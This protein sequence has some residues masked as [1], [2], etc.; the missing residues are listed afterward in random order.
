VTTL[1]PLLLVDACVLIDYVNT[2]RDVLEKVSKHAGQVHVVSTIFREVTQIGPEDV[3]H[4]GLQVIEPSLDALVWAGA[5][6]GRLSF[7]DRLALAV[8]KEHGFICVSN[9]K[10][11]RD[12]CLREGV[13]VMWGLELLLKLVHSHAIT[14]SK[15][16]Q[17]ATAIC[18]DNRWLGTAV[19]D[20]FLAKVDSGSLRRL[21]ARL[22]AY[23]LNFLSYSHLAG[24]RGVGSIPLGSLDH[25]RTWSHIRRCVRLLWCRQQEPIES[26]WH[27]SFAESTVRCIR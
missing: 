22:L 7:A 14:K 23:R 13:S 8:S 10:Q 24:T 12:Q 25:I 6:R 15:A 18:R 9:D 11:L 16:E 27:A 1:L 17:V 26:L 20:Q 19:L 21:D 2:S 5:K 4:L 3:L